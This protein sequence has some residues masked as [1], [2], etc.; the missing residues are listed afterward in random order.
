[1]IQS[2][3]GSYGPYLVGKASTDQESFSAWALMEDCTVAHGCGGYHS[4][5]RVC[6]VRSTETHRGQRRVDTPAQLQ[7]IDR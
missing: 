7:R 5:G 1:M 4:H 2:F 6:A 3:G